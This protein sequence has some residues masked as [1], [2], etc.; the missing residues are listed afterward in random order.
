M[1][2]TKIEAAK[3]KPIVLFFDM[4]NVMIGLNAVSNVLDD[5]SNQIGMYLGTM[6]MIRMLVEKYKPVKVVL[7]MDG[8]NAGEA[9][10]KLYP[11]YKGGS[12]VKAKT[13]S[14]K[15]REGEEV[16][17]YSEYTSQEAFTAQLGRIHEFVKTLPI[18]LVIVPYCEADD[19]I[20]HMVLRNKERFN[21]IIV[22]GDKDYCQLI[23]PGV[24]VYNWRE[25]I[26]YDEKTFV[27][28]FKIIP[29]N[30]I[31]MKILL[32]DSS[33]QIKGVKGIGKKTFPVFYDLL[34]SQVYNNV[35]EF[36]EATKNMDLEPLSTRERNAIKAIWS[37][38]AVEN[39]FLL[40][41][42]MHLDDNWLKLHQ[43]DVLRLQIEE[44]NP[45]LCSRMSAIIMMQKHQFNRLYSGF[46][47]DKW[48]QPFVFLRPNIIINI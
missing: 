30:Y 43:V 37:E 22:S 34:N 31:F 33:D 8:P 44:Q 5:N 6:G 25:K 36:V 4:W 14:V 2:I 19:L 39:M 18:S 41:R 40:Y 27:M 35:G 45:R 3:L 1:E 12:Y 16:D 7:A 46:D 29:Q 24:T 26:L 28:R 38:E 48:I 13:S 42:V 11:G 32:G 15:I 17:E 21:C 47:K 20:A 9:R 23:Q 10:R